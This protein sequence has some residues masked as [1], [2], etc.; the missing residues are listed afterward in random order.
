MKNL[1][2]IIKIVTKKKV[3]KIEIF[4]DQALKNKSGKF[5]E[6]YEA[7]SAGQLRN[8]R[9]AATLL[10]E[11]SPQ[12][13]KYRQLKSRFRKRL[14]NTIFFLDINKPS[15]GNYNRAYFNCNKEWAMVKILLHYGA[16]QTAT[17]MARHILT[18]A[19]KY[20]FSDLIVNCC[21]ILRQQ[22]AETG[23]DK[24]FHQYN[25][26]IKEF[27][28]ILKAELESEE[29]YQLVIINYQKPLTKKN[30]LQ[31]EIEGISA[32]LITLSEN[33]KSP[34]IFYNVYLVWAI[35][36][37]LNR[38]FDTM[39]EVCNRAEQ[40][41]DDNPNYYQEEKLIAIQN[42][43]MTAYL[44]KQDYR[45]GKV[46]A[47]KCLNRF[48]DGSQ[49]WFNFMELYLL[50]ALHTDNYINALAIVNQATDHSGLKKLDQH[51]REKWAIYVGYVSFFAAIQGYGAAVK[52]TT[53][54]RIFRPSRYFNAPESYPKSHRNYAILLLILEILELANK[55]NHQELND[56]LEK[57]KHFA[58]RQLNKEEHYRPIQFIR[59]LQQLKKAEY[60]VDQIKNAEKY[61]SAL[62]EQAFFYR[63]A[64]S[65]L[66]II[67]Y[68]KLWEIV[69]QQFQ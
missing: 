60:E 48:P 30:P 21:R 47:E 50:L 56:K 19:K 10:Y 45:K 63:G 55:R 14:L 49:P 36:F 7:L 64:I 27:E 42:K 68:E 6:F 39:L 18:T 38:E 2:E 16:T 69:L 59:L 41:M 9:D 4:D 29:L 31:E 66:E 40:Y 37:E 12:D 5:N 13:P 11:C 8:D 35:K 67:P 17:S 61:L 54:S 28:P 32:Q 44:H 25:D 1:L 22:A 3:K 65:E 15:S 26:T 53:S 52:V 33:Y 57:L 46:N 24:D 62:K 51:V 58:L 20:H 34:I 23:Q 43:K